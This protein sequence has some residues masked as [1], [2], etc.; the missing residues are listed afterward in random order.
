VALVASQ[1]RH[2]RALL[3]ERIYLG[4]ECGIQQPSRLKSKELIYQ[5]RIKLRKGDNSRQPM[6]STGLVLSSGVE[7][8]KRSG[9]VVRGETSEAI[10]P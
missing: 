1:V 9:N 6:D 8:G 10:A 2:S 5:R 4:G 7:N 3:R